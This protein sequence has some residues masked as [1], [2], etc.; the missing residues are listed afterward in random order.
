M[1]HGVHLKTS[2]FGRPVGWRGAGTV[3]PIHSIHNDLNSIKDEHVWV[4]DA[5]SVMAENVIPVEVVILAANACRKNNELCHRTI[6]QT[7]FSLVFSTL[8]NIYNYG[9]S[10]L[11]QVQLVTLVFW[12]THDQLCFIHDYTLLLLLSFI[13][14]SFTLFHSRNMNFVSF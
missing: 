10:F 9:H 14:S 11:S 4:A 13:Y 8:F 3:P 2:F 7:F 6:S 12:F 1:V 5:Q